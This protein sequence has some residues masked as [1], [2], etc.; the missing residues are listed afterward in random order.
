MGQVPVELG[1]ALRAGAA[2][3]S[4]LQIAGNRGPAYRACFR[5][6][7]RLRSLRPK[8]L[9]DLHH[10]G[11]DLPR[12]LQHHRITNPDILFVNEILVV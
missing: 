6:M 11:D 12:L 10:L 8:I 9:E 7:V 2:D 3:G 1:R 4:P 5:Q